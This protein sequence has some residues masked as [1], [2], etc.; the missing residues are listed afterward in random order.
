MVCMS[1]STNVSI[2]QEISRDTITLEISI[3]LENSFNS[4]Q[5]N[6]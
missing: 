4:E 5:F 3:L 6:S 1:A 2:P